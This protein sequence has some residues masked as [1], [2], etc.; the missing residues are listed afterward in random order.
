VRTAFRQLRNF[1]HGLFQRGVAAVCFLHFF[2][3][4]AS[5]GT[6]SGAARLEVSDPTGALSWNSTASALSVQCWFKISIPSGTTLTDNMTILVNR[7]DG[8]QADPHAYLIWFNI[9]T[10]NVEFSSQGSGLYTNTLITRPYLD[11]W[12]HVAVVREGE[13]FTGY[14]DG[15]QVFS[16]SGST[17]NAMTTEGVS[18]GG[19][20][21]GQYLYGEVQEV[22]VYQTALSQDFIVQFMFDNQPTN[23]ASLGLNGYFPLGFSTNAPDELANFAPAPVPTGTDSAS[24]KGSVPV[25]FEEVNEAGEQSAFDA[26]RN[27]GRDALTPLSGAFSWRQTAFAR[28]T[29]GI[30]M[31]FRFG[32]SSANSFGGFQLG[33]SSPYSS[34]PMGSGWRNTF[35]TRVIP[36]QTFSPLGDADT[37]GLMRWDGSIETWD[38]NYDTGEYETRN[39]E[40]NG[41]LV[42]TTTNCQ[43]TTPDR[44]IYV[45]RRP[46]SGA[47]FVM[48]GRLTSIRDFNSNAVQILWN[49]TSGVI[50][51]IVDTASGNYTF[52]YKS[53]NLLTN[54][55]FGSWQVN[56]AY[57]AT[58]R[59]ISKALTNTSGLYAAVPATWQFQYGTNGLLAGIVDP[60]GNTNI[61]VQYDQYGRQT[62]QVDAL[63]RATATLYGAPGNRQITRID[64]GTNSWVETYDRKGHILAQQDPLTN[65]TSYTYDTNGNR[66]SVTEPLGWKTFFGYDSRAN[67]IA[68]TNA[69]GEETQWVFH[70]FFNRAVQ[71][72]TP[73]PIAANGLTMWTN[74]YA[75]DAGGNLTNQ[76]DALGSLVGYTYSTNGLVLTSSDANGNSTGFAYDT[77]G[78]LVLR[79]DPAANK[80]TFN[81]N[82]LGWKLRETDALLNATSY[83]YDLNGN[84]TAVHDALSRVFNRVYDAN[85]NLLSSSDGKGLL[86][87]YAYDAANQRSSMTDRTGT[88]KWT[89]FYTLRG[90]L[91]HVTDP[92]TE[93]V[94]NSYDAANRLIRV[95]DPL[96]QSV[97]NQYDANGNLIALF[98]KL[99]QRWVK[100][101]DR[102]NRVISESDPLGNARNTSYDSAGRIQ[103]ITCP[104]GFSSVNT[105]DGRG[106][107]VKWVD[108]QTFPWL[109]AYDGVGNITNIE[110]AMHGHYVMI[111]S[112]RNERIQE[113]N[114]DGFQWDY[115]YDELLRLKVQKDPNLTTRTQTHDRAG[116]LK[117]VDFSTGRQDTFD[118]DDNDN[119][120][121]LA[122]QD[123]GIVTTT[124]L[125]YDSLDRIQEEDEP[126]GKTVLYGH[127]P[128][129][130]VTSIT[131]PGG[132]TLTNG[133]DALGRLTTQV[134]WASRQTTYFYDKADRLVGRVYPNGVVQTNTFDTAGRITGLNY[135]LPAVNPNSINVAL[136]YAYDHNGN[137]TGSSESGVFNWPLPSLTDEQSGFTAAGRL[138]TRQIQNNSAASNQLSSIAYHYDPSG[139][140][141]N[142]ADSVQSWTLA[143]DEDN[144]TT[145]IDWGSNSIST[146]VNNRYD[147]MGRRISKS[148]N[149]VKTGYVLSLVGSMERVLCDLDAGGNV[150]AWYVHGPDLSYRVDAANGLLCYHAD[151]Q[152]NIISLTDGNAN[153]VAQY[154]YTPY[155]RSLG[156][157]NF[158]SQVSNP[159]LFV[160]SQGVMEESDIP[161]LYFMRAR[162]YS[163]DAGVFLSTDPVK[164]IGPSWK[165]TSYAY[166]GNNPNAFSDPSGS[167]FGVDNLITAAIGAGIGAGVEGAW[168]I[169][170]QYMENPNHNIDWRHVVLKADEGALTGGIAGLTDGLTLVP[171]I[172]VS[173]GLGAAE[174]YVENGIDNVYKHKNFN[175]GAI[176]STL[177]GAVGG[178][179]GSASDIGVDSTS[180]ENR[181]L[182]HAIS[183][184][185][186]EFTGS[187]VSIVASGNIENRNMSSYTAATVAPKGAGTTAGTATKQA[188]PA[189]GGGTTSSG[190]GS[191][192]YVVKP[193]DTL[194]NIGYANGTSAKALGAANGIQNLNLI[195]PGQILIIPR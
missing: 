150:T 49:Q 138:T 154:A 185:L 136:A 142:A 132:I 116:R 120:R 177:F 182:K 56:F 171:S 32:Y 192:T 29:P 147:A 88:N 67:V 194:G 8:S 115:T 170:T 126:N 10:G 65:I 23:D 86:T 113:Q 75:Y 100:T 54:L 140:M 144:R 101:Y 72:I 36:A 161:N 82:E 43:W 37:V 50:T 4:H 1:V 15:R 108:P 190:G 124:Q 165:P 98:D 14:V 59:L 16:S 152:G 41:E 3:F 64:P 96:G 127:D 76:S 167:V 175:E 90:K 57:D 125:I 83:N 112:N 79:T 131:Y 19:W 62:N 163:A 97:T 174:G 158:Q 91:D 9:S 25:T 24:Q 189:T 149:G 22:S 137:K 180:I 7:H 68:K 38:L 55:T 186:G 6:F 122:R 143:Y 99:G 128:V 51:Q 141:T 168:D 173:V 118:Y 53:G 135:S 109:Y 33:S 104:N 114:Q 20:G 30:A 2:V 48:R 176:G 119:L 63:N 27:G 162:Y 157:T 95:T 44:L 151:A 139:N 146:I 130:R 148:V 166:S 74:F 106:R 191:T 172:G 103:Q 155:G 179:L 77:N 87:T 73:Q 11:R 169:A 47:N 145:S 153:L 61:A 28:P 110:D 13:N 78:F 34:G 46:D 89:Y 160:G 52:H 184:G 105:Y 26:Q 5:G 183:N 35:E 80:T 69:L 85:C 40:Y 159:Y 188:G 129:G 21:N 31:D 93:T 181:Y 187:G 123:A 133:Y 18:I 70:P 134:D 42:I 66:T 102:L 12:Y 178:F 156:S 17:G 195:H 107:L 94:V 111:Y 193:G 60:L 71:Q 58:N 117:T 45:F 121:V 164:H 39:G 92:L 81:V 84:A